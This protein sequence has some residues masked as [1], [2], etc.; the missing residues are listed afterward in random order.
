MG[1]IAPHSCQ[2]QSI[3]GERIYAFKPREI[4]EPLSEERERKLE[5]S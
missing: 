2:R 4:V 3:N 1:L 5:K